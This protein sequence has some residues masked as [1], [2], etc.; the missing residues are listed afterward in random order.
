MNNIH[1][2]SYPLE[3]SL[4]F[5]LRNRRKLEKHL[6][7]SKGY[8]K[9]SNLIKNIKYHQFDT[10]KGRHIENPNNQLKA[11]HKRLMRL[12]QRIE[13]PKFLNSGK[14]GCSHIKNTSVHT[15]NNYVLTVDI[16]S[17]YGSCRQHHI[18][19]MFKNTFKMSDD[20]AAALTRL[21]TF[22]GHLP[23]GSPVS[24]ILAYWTFNEMFNEIMFICDINNITFSLY[25][26]DM[27]FSSKE[28][29]TVSFLDDIKRVVRSYELTLKDSKEKYYK[30]SKFKLI[31]GVAIDP[32]NRVKVSNNLRSKTINK[33]KKMKS[34]EIEVNKKSLQ[35]LIGLHSSARQIESNIFPSIHHYINEKKKEV[36]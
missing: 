5:R 8:L 1:I 4:L 32:K 33:F 3:N 23:T 16:K 22:D 34:G 31:T 18:H 24:Q 21:V 9:K 29:L 10:D 19:K 13:T 12:L 20:I 25:V 15:K 11:I 26:D 27:T 2:K 14:K 36:F 7:T 30:A 17:F 6:G 28:K 35:K